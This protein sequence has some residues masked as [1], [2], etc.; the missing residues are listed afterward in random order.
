[1]AVFFLIGKVHIIVID[2]T[3]SKVGKLSIRNLGLGASKWTVMTG[4]SGWH[5]GYHVHETLQEL[6]NPVLL[7]G[8]IGRHECAHSWGL[9]GMNC[10]P[11]HVCCWLARTSGAQKG[12]GV[13][14]PR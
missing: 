7:W 8:R 4:C 12:W 3:V 2:D 11:S 1:M 9:P 14:G 6:R 5:C 13:L 10:D